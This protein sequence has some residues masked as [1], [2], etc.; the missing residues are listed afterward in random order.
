MSRT[1]WQYMNGQTR[2]GTPG[3]P[4]ETS[5]TSG[6]SPKDYHKNAVAFHGGDL[7][8]EAWVK[9][10]RKGYGVKE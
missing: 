7:A 5:G 3:R 9:A 10:G 8:Y 1:K 4:T 6:K 2:G